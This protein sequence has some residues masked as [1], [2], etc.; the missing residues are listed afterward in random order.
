MFETY[1]VINTYHTEVG[2]L[3][4]KTQ[5]GDQTLT[6]ELTGYWCINV[7]HTEMD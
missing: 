5:P 3:N 2:D 6:L 1:K 4:P 7:V